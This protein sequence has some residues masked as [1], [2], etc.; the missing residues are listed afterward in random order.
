MKESRNTRPP[1]LADKLL[2]WYC[3]NA[4][5]EDL[6]GDLEE[7]FYKDLKDGLFRARFKYWKRTLSLLS[8][9]AIRK[10]KQKSAFHQYSNFSINPAM[11]KNYFLIAV[12]GLARHKLFTFINVFGLAV[13]MSF[14]LLFLAM[15]SFLF[16]YDNFHVNKD[17][18]YRIISHVQDNDRN[19]SFASTP[20]GLADKLK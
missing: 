14:S 13:G 1:R 2:L 4:A 10:R 12:R 17:K 8:S 3:E 19:P 20:A 18:I 15:L 5:I 16:T 7:L 6:H 9:Y 11:F